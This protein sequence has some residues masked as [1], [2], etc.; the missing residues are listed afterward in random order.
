MV[1]FVFAFVTSRSSSTLDGCLESRTLLKFSTRTEILLWRFDI[2]P[3]SSRPRTLDTLL[4]V[5]S[6]SPFSRFELVKADLSSALSSF[7]PS[8]P[9]LFAHPFVSHLAQPSSLSSLNLHLA[10][11]QS[12][13]PV[14][15]LPSPLPPPS[16]PSNS[17]ETTSTTTS[18]APKPTCTR[19]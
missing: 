8:S 3:D 18:N 16:R 6:G 13:S 19:G 10:N 12:S 2:S 5:R 15:S 11:Y 1:P 7:S 4:S 9:P 14:T 17:S